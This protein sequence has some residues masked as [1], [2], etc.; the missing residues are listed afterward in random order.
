ME[1]VWR[2]EFGG[3]VERGVARGETKR[4]AR[5]EGSI[6]IWSG[7]IGCAITTKVTSA[8]GPA[9]LRHPGTRVSDC[10][11][12]RSLPGEAACPC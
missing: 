5:A 4:W 6:A 1:G 11:R 8:A 10:R 7:W 3:G 12:K 2:K 9:Q